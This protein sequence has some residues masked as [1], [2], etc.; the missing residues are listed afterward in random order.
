MQGELN[1]GDARGTNFDLIKR[2]GPNQA[3][4][5][6]LSFLDPVR[7]QY[8]TKAKPTPASKLASEIPMY[9][10]VFYARRKFQKH[11]SY[12]IQVHP[13]IVL[14][15]FA[16]RCMSLHGSALVTQA[17]QDGGQA[18]DGNWLL[19]RRPSLC[20]RD[21]QEIQN[22]GEQ[23]ESTDLLNRIGKKEKLCYPQEMVE[24]CW[25]LCLPECT[26]A[27]TSKRRFKTR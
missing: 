13:P 2:G 4:P 26:S 12:I 27:K 19:L 11:I 16:M 18:A 5:D 24:L 7:S 8:S 22:F 25:T 9:H 23:Q 21:T 15:C 1:R 6:R 17:A 20:R 14:Q 3:R 10:I